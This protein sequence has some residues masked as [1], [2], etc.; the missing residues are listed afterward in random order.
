MPCRIMDL[1]TYP[2]TDPVI[3]NATEIEEQHV[4]T[5]NEKARMNAKERKLK[6]N[7]L[8]DRATNRLINST[9]TLGRSRGPRSTDVAPSGGVRID[10]Q[11]HGTRVK[12]QRTLASPPEQDRKGSNLR[13][14][15]RLPG[16]RHSSEDAKHF[17]L[18]T[19]V[20]S[21]AE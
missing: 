21:Q 17:D 3:R 8:P 20:R 7:H 2:S 10:C 18:S 13:H 4:L 1:C 19:G 6:R 9:T 12:T 15:D 11:V 16:Q 14:E 5:T